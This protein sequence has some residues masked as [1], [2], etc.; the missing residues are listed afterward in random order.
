MEFLGGN[1]SLYYSVSKRYRYSCKM[2]LEISSEKYHFDQNKIEIILRE[3][4]QRDS[5]HHYKPIGK[6]STSDTRETLL[7]HVLSVQNRV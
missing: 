6:K 5:N 4:E 1:E 7:L 3:R 2:S